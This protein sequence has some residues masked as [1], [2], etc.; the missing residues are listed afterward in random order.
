MPELSNEEML[1][2]VAQQGSDTPANDVKPEVNAPSPEPQ[3]YEYT[4]NGR[5]VKEPLEMIL[6]RASQGYHYSQQME[7][8]NRERQEIERIKKENESLS[9]W[10]RYDD[11]AREHPDWNKH[12]QE[13]W[14]KRSS[15]QQEMQDDPMFQRIV[16]L[17]NQLKSY[18][19]SYQDKFKTYDSF[20]EKAQYEKDEQALNTEIKGVREAYKHLDFDTP[21]GTGRTLEYRVLE[22]MKNQ[23]IP[24]FKTA[25]RDLYFEDALKAEGERVK[26]SAADEIQR[27]TKSG[28]LGVSSTPQM[29]AETKRPSTYEEAADFA[30]KELGLN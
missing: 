1:A 25:F 11:Y 8:L 7:A 4:A 2:S 28:I 19:E 29:K 23:Q 3:M 6:K 17:E 14:E 10:K 20:L 16:E 30:K 12:F 5:T 21:D 26:K 15:Y 27:R 24:S 13:S 9:Q 18:Q 22:H